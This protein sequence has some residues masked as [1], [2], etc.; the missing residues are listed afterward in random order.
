MSQ[1][2]EAD[3]AESVNFKNQGND[4]F[5]EQNYDEAIKMYSL[6]IVHPIL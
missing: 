2:T 1:P 4:Y 5:K 3:L 6:A